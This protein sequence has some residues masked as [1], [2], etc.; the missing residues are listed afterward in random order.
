VLHAIVHPA[1]VQDR[2][3][4]ITLLATLS[5]TQPFLTKLL[6]RCLSGAGFHSALNENLPH[7]ETEIVK[8][9]S[10]KDLWC[11]PSAGSSSAHL[12]WL[13]R[14]RRLA[15]DW[16]TS[17]QGHRILASCLNPPHASKLA[18]LLNVRTTLRARRRHSVVARELGVRSVLEGSF[19]ARQPLRITA[20][21]IDAQTG[22]P[23]GRPL[24]SRTERRL[25]GP[26]R[27]TRRS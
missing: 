6:R 25:R 27:V 23:L 14:C 19:A 24:R 26:G 10:A 18:I 21:L 9:R 2:D 5:G 13:N 1:D 8:R 15:K 22:T 11:C 3:G 20:Q 17:M 12:A 16:E 7:L 4:G